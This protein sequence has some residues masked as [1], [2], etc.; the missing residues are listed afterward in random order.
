MVSGRQISTSAQCGQLSLLSRRCSRSLF[1]RVRSFARSLLCTIA[2]RTSHT[3]R[4]GDS[5][6]P[7]GANQP[8]CD[9][10]LNPQ[11]LPSCTRVSEFLCVCVFVCEQKCDCEC[12]CS[13]NL[14][15]M[16]P[17]ECVVVSFFLL[18]PFRDSALV[19]SL[20]R[21]SFARLGARFERQAHQR[22]EP[23]TGSGR[24]GS[25]A[26]SPPSCA[27]GANCS[28]RPGRTRLVG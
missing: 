3:S 4:P 13:R 25:R 6:L 11:Q 23:S 26:Q 2:R 5:S 1:V 8:I 21:R 17:L 27:C 9:P 18:A 22:A 28:E 15:T 24:V 19:C 12:G 20:A 10:R 16:I 7:D 14:P